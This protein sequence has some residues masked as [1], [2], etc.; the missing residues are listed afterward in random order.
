MIKP[1]ATNDSD[2]IKKLEEKFKSDGYGH[3]FERLKKK[4]GSLDPY[5]FVDDI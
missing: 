4:N 5:A 2:V 3:T 1:N